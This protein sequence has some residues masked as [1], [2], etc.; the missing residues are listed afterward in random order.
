M[1]NAKEL[2]Q[3]FNKEV[4]LLVSQN[5][6]SI[7]EQLSRELDA[8]SGTETTLSFSVKIPDYKFVDELILTATDVIRKNLAKELEG[9]GYKTRVEGW[10]WLSIKA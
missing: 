10:C 9:L 4:E 6:G 7:R 5:L 3:A 2:K 1:K 8:I